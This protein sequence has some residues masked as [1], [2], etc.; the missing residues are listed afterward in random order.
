MTTE[1]LSDISQAFF[2]PVLTY[3]EEKTPRLCKSFCCAWLDCLTFLGGMH[4][5][6]EEKSQ[7]LTISFDFS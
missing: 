2:L 6:V 4:P 3:Q 5:C 7:V 1:A